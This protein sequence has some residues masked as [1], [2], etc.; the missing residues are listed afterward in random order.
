MKKKNI[1]II[2]AGSIGNHFA[3]ASRSL[4]LNV[5]VSDKYSIALKRIKFIQKDII[6]GIKKFIFLSLRKKN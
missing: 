3:N 5:Y 6:N 1:L 2:G 4:G